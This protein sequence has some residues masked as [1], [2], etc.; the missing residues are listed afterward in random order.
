[1]SRGCEKYQSRARV[2]QVN[3]FDSTPVPPP[4]GGQ[5]RA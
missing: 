2:N 1:M 3:K 4:T 5:A